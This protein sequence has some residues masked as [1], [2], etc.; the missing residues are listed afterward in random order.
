MT[1]GRWKEVEEWIK[2]SPRS[3]R[4]CSI[5]I[6]YILTAPLVVHHPGNSYSSIL[7]CSIIYPGLL[8]DPERGNTDCDFS[9]WWLQ[10]EKKPKEWSLAKGDRPRNLR[11]PQ[12]GKGKSHR[13]TMTSLLEKKVM[14]GTNIVFK[15][16]VRRDKQS[17]SKKDFI[18]SKASSGNDCNEEPSCLIML[19]SNPNL[20]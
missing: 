8:S 17:L 7:R 5:S 14:R 19:N 10:K 18:P 9:T 3:L 13:E 20:P 2:H 6:K 1:S 4:P 16:L 11:I 12:K 15:R